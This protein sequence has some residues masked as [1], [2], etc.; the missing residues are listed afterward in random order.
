MILFLQLETLR[1]DVETINYTQLISKAFMDINIAGPLSVG[2]SFIAMKLVGIDSVMSPNI[3]TV[4]TCANL[5][6]KAVLY[7]PSNWIGSTIYTE[8]NGSS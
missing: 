8:I 7:A 6:F 5:I 2:N 1:L 3:S 4:S